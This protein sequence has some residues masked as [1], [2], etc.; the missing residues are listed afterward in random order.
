MTQHILPE[1]DIEDQQTM[2]RLGTV[3]GIFILATAVMA[4]SVGV[5]MG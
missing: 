5:I 2:R 3:I 1:H 4:V